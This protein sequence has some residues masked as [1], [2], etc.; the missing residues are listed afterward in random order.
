M[1]YCP[2]CGKELIGN[3]SFCPYCGKPLSLTA[4]LETPTDNAL[5]T[6]EK[7]VVITKTKPRVSKKL[8][9]GILIG[10]IAIAVAL[11]LLTNPFAGNFSEDTDAIQKAG[12]SVVKIY[13]Y[14]INGIEIGT[15]SAFA[16]LDKDIIITNHHCIEGNV[17]SIEAERADSSFFSIES[18]VAYDKEKDIAILRAPESNLTPLA[19]GNSS[20]IKRGEKTVA[21]GS[22][23]GIHQMISTGV[24]SNYL[25]AKTHI[26]ILSTAS[27]SHGSSGGALLNNHGKVI[28]ITSGA[29]ETGNDLYYSIPMYYAQELYNNRDPK[30]EITLAEFYNLSEHP[31]DVNYILAFGR[32]LNG[33]EV[34]I[35]GY[36]S[37]IGAQ[38]DLVSRPEDVIYIDN[39]AP[40]DTDDWWEKQ[41]IIM[42]HEEMNYVL[43]I[44]TTKSGQCPQ[45]IQPGDK[46]EIK[47]KIVYYPDSAY[48]DVLAT[49]VKEIS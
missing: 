6:Q 39:R 3:I 44:D 12:N 13:M 46:V 23:I 8:I 49:T 20:N 22:P 43:Q 41:K 4:S 15:G 35:H 32:M 18:V 27:I 7:P 40:K 16:A 25:D 2:H 19:V 9:F 31:Y 29:Y 24:F 10:F 17:Y 36:A 1:K 5:S 14:D 48:F 26:R 47:G 45:S 38:I 11:V 33:K 21:I 30:N 34:T 37:C 42:E 28:G